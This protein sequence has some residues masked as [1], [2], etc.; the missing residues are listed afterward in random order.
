MKATY[1]ANKLQENQYA[2][3]ATVM[4]KKI[5]KLR[6]AGKNLDFL[7]KFFQLWLEQNVLHVTNRDRSRS[8]ILIRKFFQEIRPNQG[9]PDSRP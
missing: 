2:L 5:Q 9:Y 8:K 6:Q 3:H 1:H 4:M 7:R